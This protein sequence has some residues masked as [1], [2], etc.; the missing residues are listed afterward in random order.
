MYYS[1]L[2]MLLRASAD[3]EAG[4]VITAKCF[5]A[6]KLCLESHVTCFKAWEALGIASSDNVYANR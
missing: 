6:A 3:V 5:N 4:L 1:T 2:T